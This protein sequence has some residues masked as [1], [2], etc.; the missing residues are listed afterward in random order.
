[1]HKFTSCFA[2]RILTCAFLLLVSLLLISAAL[3]EP[4]SPELMNGLKWRLIG[5][6]RGGRVVAVAGVPGDSTTF[7]FGSVNGGIWKTTDAGVVWTPIFDSQPVGSIGALAV[8][9]SDPKTIYAGTG[10]SDIRSDL[11]SGN[12][13]YKSTDGGASWNHIGLEDTRQISRIMI[14]PQNPNIVYVGVLGHAY[15]PGVP[16]SSQQR[17][18]QQ[19]GVY[20]SVDGGAHWARVL[21]L[22][23]EIGISDLAM[24]SSAPQLLFAGAWHAHRPPWSVYAPIE[25]PGSGLYRSQDA[26]KTWTRLHG[27]GLP[28]GDWGRVGVDVAPDG[29]RVYA[30]IVLQSETQ[31]ETEIPTQAKKSGLYRSDDGG[32]T[33]TLA[34]SDPRLTSRA[35]Y[36][37]RVTVDPQN[38]DVLYIPNVAFYRSEDGGKTVSIV[39]G[40]PGGDD[41]HQL[42]IDPRN[43]AS[44]VLGTDQGT[45]ISLNRGRTW[46]SW[47][48]QP[49][50]Q[51]YHVT[52]DNQ[53][54]YVVYGA[55]QDSGSAAVVS[56]TDHDQITPRDW[57]PAGESESGYM[58]VDP[59]DPNIV[60]LSGTYGTVARFNKRTGLSQDI[61][62][63]PAT[64]FDAPIN[65]R[66][67]RDPWTPVL[68]LSPVDRTTLFLGT[69]FVMTTVDG[70]L[71]WEAI[72]PDLTGA[73]GRTGPD[74]HGAHET[75][76]NK[77]T[78]TPNTT[79]TIE[80]AKRA[81]YGVV[82]TIAPSPL[83]RDLIWAG[84]DTGL[85]HL[86]RDGGKNW[87]DVSPPG[88]SDWSK[89]SM[90]EASHFDPAVAYAA[91]DR[92]RLDDQT[93]Y[94]Y[95]TRDYGATW[96]LVTNG[97]G[98]PA[99]LR[100]IREDPQDKDLLF[101]GTEFGVYVSL[102]D[103]DHWQSLQ[104]NLPVSSVRDLTIHG[105]DLV[106]GTHGRSFWI[107]DNIT[108]LRQVQPLDVRRASDPRLYRPATAVRMDNDSFPGTPLP[109]EEPTAENPPNGAM[110]DYFLPSS[111]STVRLE[112]FD[113]QQNLVRQFSSQGTSMMKHSLIPVA[114]RWFPKPEV[115][116]KTAGMHRFVWDL[117]WHSSGSP[118]ADED[119]EYH[120]PRG[121]KAVPGIYQVRL[122]IDGKT[123]DQSLTVIMDPRSPATPEVLAQQLHLGQ[124]IF[125]ETI[126]A[127]R[128]LAEIVSVQ[129]QLADIQQKLE[130]NKLEARSTTLKAALAEAQSGIAR[131]LTNKEQATEDPGL[132]D[133]YTALA[134]ALRV[135]ESGDRTV[136]SQAIALYKES[137]PQVKAR[138]AE[139]IRF[140]QTRLVQLNQQLREADFS[141]IAISEIEQEVDFLIS[142]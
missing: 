40:A 94:I 101:A 83:N 47:Y 42:W 126:E 137:S 142:R 52:T 133:A 80:E 117:A 73:I 13:V 15:D 120:S 16:G 91:V 100:A 23:P 79:P 81:G 108:P 97:I 7:Y 31:S 136:P 64:R 34:N 45:T 139:W 14:D 6:F 28:E 67:Y 5:P 21:D 102:D 118:D 121:P 69:Q 72:S 63:W 24:S 88:L 26:G 99:F 41:Y 122:T 74:A 95:R 141:P 104:L 32:N 56:R 66:K 33:W 113:A 109:P 98:A 1:L 78:S 36:F 53:F 128:A 3:A 84:S 4:V 25:G 116:E 87:T 10:E 93:P 96:Q 35:W 18:S 134:S 89:I 112:V 49:T 106:I 37:N 9:P 77:A 19:R 11:S 140:K 75:E 29:K 51:L 48:N 60:Y 54:P 70:G 129:K 17:S 76:G 57:F 130:Q 68:V 43:S 110:I 135:V 58:V 114:E 119:A 30:L 22:G 62:P 59:N 20:K 85:I 127:H 8:A 92:S 132:K 27:N 38:P 86:T 39:R 71:H 105:D 131:I 107:L 44:M 61:S 50:A 103:G 111:A 125:A 115:L 46:S 2:R 90:I 82:F 124:Q 138:I 123:Q 12:G 65:Q 55:Q